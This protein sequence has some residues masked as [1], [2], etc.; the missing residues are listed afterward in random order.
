MTVTCTHC[1]VQREVTKE[2]RH[3]DNR[4]RRCASKEQVQIYQLAKFRICEVCGDKKK[5]KSDNEAKGKICKSCR[6]KQS[7]GF[8]RI[9][10]DCGDT[11]EVDNERDSRAE[12]CKPCSAK[13]VAKG[14]IG[15]V[16]K[17]PKKVYWYFCGSCNMVQ[18]KR[19]KQG[20]RFCITCN[21][22]QPRRK[23]RLPEIYFDMETMKMKIPMRH[24]RICPHCPSDNNTK[25]V[26]VARLAG[27]KPCAKHKY[28]D[29]PEALALKEAKRQATR[30]ANKPKHKKIYKKSE[31]KVSKHAIEKQIEL[32]RQHKEKVKE[33]PKKIRQTKTDDEMM[34]EF[35][36]NN[37]VT[38]IEPTLHHRAGETDCCR[39]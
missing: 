27:I 17:V 24:V 7:S 22:K 35:L 8:K 29:N 33:V 11:K 16:S 25:V 9:C 28:V 14:R 34:A 36:A 32:N 23:N 3:K 38:T 30:K 10:V 31:K 26:Q 37:T 19:T 5:V 2:P 6:T 4:C 21:R 15:T 20:G 39:L 12:R 1:N 18:V 13:H